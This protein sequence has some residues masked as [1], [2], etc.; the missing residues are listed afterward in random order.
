MSKVKIFWQESCPNCPP[1]KELG[2]RLAA[3]GATVEYYNVKDTDGLTEAVLHGLM[4]TPSVVVV[5]DD[6]SEKAVWRGA[7][8]K[9]EE[10][11]A[12]LT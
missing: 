2:K 4:S 12:A 11:K 7:A 6:G 9:L 1:A 5:A 3:S 8:P 10:V